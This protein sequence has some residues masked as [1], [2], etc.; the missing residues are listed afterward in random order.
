MAYAPRTSPT[1]LTLVFNEGGTQGSVRST[2][3]ARDLLVRLARTPGL[4]QALPGQ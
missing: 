3:L 1:W 2:V 4:V